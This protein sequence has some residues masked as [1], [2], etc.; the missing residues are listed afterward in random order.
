MLCKKFDEDGPARRIQA[1]ITALVVTAAVFSA[2]SA[3]AASVYKCAADGDRC[4]VRI[5]DGIIGD[6]VRVL[7]EKARVIAQGRIIS[8]KGT[9][10][11]ITVSNASK[12]IR[13]GYPVIVNIE[14]RKSDYQWAASFSDKD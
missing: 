8:R 5:E 14:N 7:D 1:W 3:S 9:Y 10:A 6:Q 13:K 4:V 12:T 11:V 2:G